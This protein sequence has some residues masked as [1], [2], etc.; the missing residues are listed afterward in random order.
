MA[1]YDIDCKFWAYLVK[2]Y[3]ES[4]VTLAETDMEIELLLKTL[5][6][7][8]DMAM[9]GIHIMYNGPLPDIGFEKCCQ[10]YKEIMKSNNIHYLG[11]IKT[12]QKSMSEVVSDF[13]LVSSIWKCKILIKNSE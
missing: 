8:L 3:E 4:C 10:L 7:D 1:K 6:T 2:I 11:R 9:S 5:K 12:I 13:E